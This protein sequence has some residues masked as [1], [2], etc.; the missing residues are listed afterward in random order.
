MYPSLFALRSQGTQDF[1]WCFKAFDLVMLMSSGGIS[2]AV[3]MLEKY[4]YAPRKRE[5]LNTCSLQAYA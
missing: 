5:R 2:A 1:G 3:A 4:V